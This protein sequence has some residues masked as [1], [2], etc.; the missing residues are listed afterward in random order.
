MTISEQTRVKKQQQEV[1]VVAAVR[2]PIGKFNGS[3][4]QFSAV[5][6]ISETGLLKELLKRGNVKTQDI[7]EVILGNVLGAGLG[8]NIAR[9]VA[10]KSGLPVTTPAL[11]VNRVCASSLTAIDLASN[12]IATGR[13]EVIIAGGTESMSNAPYLMPRHAKHKMGNITLIDTMIKDGLWD[14]FYDYHMGMTAENIV[15]EWNISRA[16][17][18]TYALQSHQKTIAAQKTDA[19]AEEI[20]P[21]AVKDKKTNAVTHTISKDEGPREDTSVE[22]LS[23]LK[24]AFLRPAGSVTAA[25]A[26][27]INDGAALVLLTSLDY[28]KKNKLPMLA[29]II[30]QATVG[31]DPKIMGHAPYAAILK[32]IPDCINDLGAIDLFEINEAF[33]AQCLAVIKDLKLEPAKINVHG[34][35]I[36]LGHPIGASGARIVVTLLHAMKRLEKRRGVASL[37]VGGGQGVA[38]LFERG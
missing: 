7:A 37:C 17:Q 33:A 26:S 30:G 4:A 32:L 10:V 34:G 31:V 36:A 6:L 3:L 38:M 1:V 24:P 21:I 29:K 13:A 19:F 25:N 18:D 11:T 2:T 14:V 5:E 28:A 27:T 22:K 35:A 16:S 23:A 15:A 12:I 20:M 8:Q 9:Q